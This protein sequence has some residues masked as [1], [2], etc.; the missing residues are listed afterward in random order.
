MGRGGMAR[1]Q[2][3]ARGE[4]MVSGEGALR[5]QGIGGGEEAK[6]FL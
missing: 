4:G 1:G 5:T 6:T 3:M 2:G